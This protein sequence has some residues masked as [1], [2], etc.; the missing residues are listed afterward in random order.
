MEETMFLV[1]KEDGTK[2]LH[3]VREGDLP[4][5]V[6]AA[7]VFT[8]V[9]GDVDLANYTVVNDGKLA[10][11][12][13]LK[14]ENGN[15][16]LFIKHA[17]GTRN[18]S[19]TNPYVNLAKDDEWVVWEPVDDDG[20]MYHYEIEKGALVHNPPPPYTPSEEVLAAQ[21]LQT[22]LK[23]LADHADVDDA[24]YAKMVRISNIQDLAKQK[25]EFDKL[26]PIL[27]ITGEIALS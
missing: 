12:P 5:D 1:L 16:M 22:K 10:H 3:D 24:T 27:P 14:P 21:E 2:V 11:I 7:A 20:D 25:A 18:V 26:K 9:N 8:P 17:D 6:Q 19:M 13:P 4:Q 23:E 15:V